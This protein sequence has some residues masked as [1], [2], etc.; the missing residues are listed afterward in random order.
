MLRNNKERNPEEI[1]TTLTLKAKRITMQAVQQRVDQREGFAR[2][3]T[4]VMEAI[5]AGKSDSD[6]L[7]AGGDAYFEFIKE[8]CGVENEG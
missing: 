5:I 8:T 4:V 2:A 6:C 3:R 7:I 1:A